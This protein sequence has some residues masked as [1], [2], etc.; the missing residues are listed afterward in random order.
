MIDSQL[1]DIKERVLEPVAYAL[2][3]STHPTTVTLIGGMVGI[4]CAVSAAVGWFGLGLMLWL[5]NRTLDGLDG[6]LARIHGRQSDIGG[7][8]DILVD[9]AVYVLVPVGLI[10]A[11]PSL[12]SAAALVFLLGTFYLNSASWIY[13]A[14]ILERRNRGARARGE[15]TTITMPTGWVEGAET[16]AFYVLFFL[17]PGQ[18]P[19]LFGLMG[20]AVVLT[21]VQRLLWAVNTL[22]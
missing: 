18:L 17:F 19:L 22:D 1:R 10:V 7:Y 12:V 11:D 15:K 20:V 5:L 6:T 2:G 21:V 8:V 16:V 4:A 9:T 14:A 3:E 13:L